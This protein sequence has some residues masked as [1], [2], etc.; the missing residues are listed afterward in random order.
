MRKIAPGISIESKYL[1]TLLGVVVSDDG[2]LLIDSPLLVE[3]GRD[4]LASVRKLG[5]PRYLALLD[6]YPDRVLGARSSNLHLIAHDATR[7]EIRSWPDTFKGSAHPIGAEADRLKR[8]TGVHRA[9]PELTFSKE[10]TLHLGERVIQFTHKPGPRR[11]AMWVVLHEVGVAFIGDA[12]TK[13]EPPYLGKSNLEAWH[14]TLDE[15]RD[16]PFEDY[17]LFCSRDGEIG[18]E[19]V[20]AMARFLRKVPVRLDRMKEQEKPLEATGK[21]AQELLGDF[22]VAKNKRDQARFRLEA[23][24]KDLYQTLY[25]KE[26]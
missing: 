19:D 2:L 23:G 1:T 3:D 6:A 5:Q 26:G 7:K 11:G 24:L 13:S 21:Y 17:R 20:N 18:R 22:S 9:I 4:W 12:V 10:M 8:I 25:E 15:L 16:Q 14:E